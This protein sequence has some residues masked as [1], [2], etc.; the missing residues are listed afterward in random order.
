MQPELHERAHSLVD[1]SMM[2][3]ISPDEQRWL[4]HHISQ[5]AECSQYV[6]LSR[7]AILALD[8]FAFDLDP[9]AALRTQNAIRAR[10]GRMASHGRDSSIAI[11][12]AIVLTIIGS[13]AMWESAGWLASRWKLPAP[14]WQIGFAM[15]WVLPSVLLDVLLL[16]R[17]KLI[18]GHARGPS[19]QGAIR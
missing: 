7:R 19:G 9:E 15:L 3:G 16:F 13:I 14:T 10:A 12:A 17:G 18:A 8:S 5:C 11:S 4:A 6:G 2:E 1:R